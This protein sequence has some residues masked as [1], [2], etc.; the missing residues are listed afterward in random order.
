MANKKDRLRDSLSILNTVRTQAANGDITQV[1]T[2]QTV[3]RCSVFT[4]MRD[5]E[6]AARDIPNQSIEL[7]VEMRKKTVTEYGINEA[8]EVTT[9]ETGS[10]VFQVVRVEFPTLR[11]AR[12][13]LS[14][15][16]KLTD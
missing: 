12:L 10:R 16:S 15:K 2:G 4:G 1:V 9:S 8:T 14:G 13:I 5:I 3:L 11:K 6:Y 7:I